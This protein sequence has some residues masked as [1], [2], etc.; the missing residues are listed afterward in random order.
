MKSLLLIP[1]FYFISFNLTAQYEWMKTYSYNLDNSINSVD[2]TS[3]CGF[4]IAGGEQ[5]Q[6]AQGNYFV[7]KLDSNGNEIWHVIGTRFN[8]IYGDNGASCII[9]SGDGGCLVGGSLQTVNDFDLYFIRIDS[10]GNVL[11]EKTYGGM[12]D[13]YIG[14]II[15]N[16][17]N[18]LCTC[19]SL[20][21]PLQKYL[22]ALD[23][24][25]DSLWSKDLNTGISLFSSSLIKI[26]NGNIVS[27]GAIVDSVNNNL[28]NLSYS[29]I[30]TSG[31]LQQIKV[32]VDTLS[33]YPE[34]INQ[35]DDGGFLFSSYNST[36]RISKITKVN[37]EGVIQWERTF[38]N[39]K[40]CVS[41]ILNDNNYSLSV[42]TFNNSIIIIGFDSLGNIISRDSIPIGYL[43]SV[44][45][46]NI[47]DRN[48][49]LIIC[50]TMYDSNSCMGCPSVGIILKINSSSINTINELFLSNNPEFKVFPNPVNANISDLTIES[51]DLI[52]GIIITDITGNIIFQS[53]K[54][55]I[56][57]DF[58][59]QLQI[60]NKLS[61]GI[62]FIIIVNKFGINNC[63]KIIVYN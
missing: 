5:G 19:I 53:E 57:N 20:S 29:E 14:S 25:G 11:W 46:D 31:N 12:N 52:N 8:G 38:S 26:I 1:F 10:T 59:F 47:T 33:F 54:N 60:K 39:T 44:L 13:Q 50:G 41:T 62:Y 21:N 56:I 24:Q 61:V 35:T 34:T 15:K 32:F 30:D 36:N 40:Y 3:D 27:F 51:S 43:Q 45:F 58:K 2:T 48:G 4:F 22:L 7:A 42:G 63:K 16:G 23:D 55:I 17:N 6:G 9:N 49:D 37:F 18:Y 28:I